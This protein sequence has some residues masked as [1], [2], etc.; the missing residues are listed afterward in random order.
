MAR[1]G[2]DIF[3]KFLN[4]YLKQVGILVG[5]KLF[6]SEVEFQSKNLN[7]FSEEIWPDFF[8]KFSFMQKNFM[9]SDV[10]KKL[11]ELCNIVPKIKRRHFRQDYVTQSKQDTIH[12]H[13]AFVNYYRIRHNDLN[14]FTLNLTKFVA[15]QFLQNYVH[16]VLQNKTHRNF[17][18]TRLCRTQYASI[19]FRLLQNSR[20]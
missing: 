12:M 16:K 17:W 10:S 13:R 3:I 18:K 11:A 6:L 4:S 9:W 1:G 2:L 14:R 5:N 19:F 20:H 8:A 7:S 15:V